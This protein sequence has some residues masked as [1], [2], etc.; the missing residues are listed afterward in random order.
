MPYTVLGFLYRLL[1]ANALQ[2]M[3][4]IHELRLVGKMGPNKNC[5]EKLLRHAVVNNLRC[6]VMS[7]QVGCYSAAGIVAG[8]VTTASAGFLSWIAAPFTLSAA[9]ACNAAMGA[10]SAQ[11]AVLAGIA[12]ATPTP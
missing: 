6:A 11:C 3:T 7:L 9:T 4:L 12:T 5:V 1:S 10:C 2:L 8:T